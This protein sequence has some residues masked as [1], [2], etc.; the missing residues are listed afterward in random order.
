MA[1]HPLINNLVL[2]TLLQSR[3][4][5]ERRPNNFDLSRDVVASVAVPWREK[6]S[7]AYPSSRH[8]QMST[9]PS[10]CKDTHYELMAVVDVV[11]VANSNREIQLQ[12]SPREFSVGQ[13][14]LCPLPRLNT[15][16][17]ETD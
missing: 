1:C 15:A 7:K 10:S 2:T 13:N 6:K 8:Q 11:V 5:V 17:P 4:G 14:F 16:T 3:E 12:Q 9:I